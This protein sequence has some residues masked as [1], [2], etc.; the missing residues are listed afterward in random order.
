MADE[1]AEPRPDMN[2][3]VAAFTVSEKSIN[4]SATQGKTIDKWNNYAFCINA[5]SVTFRVAVV[6]RVFSGRTPR[7]ALAFA[8]HLTVG[9]LEAELLKSNVYL[10]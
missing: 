6:W 5:L 2:I 4:T 3:K 1:I 8:Q 10:Q 7:T 9:V